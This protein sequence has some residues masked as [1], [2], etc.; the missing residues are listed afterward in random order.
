MFATDSALLTA[1]A[2]RKSFGGV[3]VLHGVDL[4]LARGEVLALLGENG[5]GKST[6]VKILA[7]D[8]VADSGSVS[9]GDR[10]YS[11]LDPIKS[12]ALG[13]RMIFQEL[14]DAPL[15]TVAENISMG[16]WASKAGIVSW[17]KMH[18]RANSALAMLGIE[19]DS[20]RLVGTLRI[21]ERQLVEIARAISDNAQVLILD[22]PTAALSSA[23]T[24]KL[25]AVINALRTRGVGMIYITHRLDEVGIIADRVQV[26]RDGSQSLIADAKKATRIELVK[27]MIGHEI[28]NQA[29]PEAGMHSGE[30]LLEV[31]QLSLGNIFSDISF[32]LRAGEVLAL[33]GKVGSGAEEVGETIFGL[34]PDA[35]GTLTLNQS[36]F[37]PKNP[38]DAIR[39][40]IGFLP[41]DRQRLG[42]FMVRPVA[43][44]LA[45][46]SW[47]RYA[48]RGIITKVKENAAYMRWSELL[49]IKSRNDPDQLIATLSGG[50]QQKVL[51]SRWFEC[52]AKVLVLIEPTRG[53]DVG[54]RRDI[55]NTLRE[56]A[57]KNKIGILITTSDHEEVIQVADRVV[58]MS[59][60]KKVAE[61]EGKNID[62]SQIIQT[63][64]E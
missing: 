60:G 53:V 25:F 24:D 59:R 49:K 34:H 14:S 37:T 50:N 23:E 55:Y 15:L 48:S 43:E 8:Y 46:P 40:F 38:I 27:A 12:R 29:H 61:Y 57:K 17:S 62:S 6:L 1:S 5:A 19:I 58:V 42:A 10:E 2:I 21:G 47:P 32:N 36:T 18:E 9:S 7:G 39:A 35:T 41:A 52:D 20:S 63:A 64:S 30:T 4:H 22:E 54:A 11:T 26:L 44:N 31:S 51:L 13:I 45:V 56:S 16:S 33:Y 28:T 3:E